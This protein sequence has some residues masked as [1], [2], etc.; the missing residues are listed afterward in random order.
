MKYEEALS[1]NII[2]DEALTRFKRKITDAKWS[3]LRS[4][5]WNLIGD[6][7]DG[8]IVQGKSNGHR[9]NMTYANGT[10]WEVNGE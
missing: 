4:F 3:D 10:E 2:A 6:F 7:T 5:L 9:N 8:Q 1:I